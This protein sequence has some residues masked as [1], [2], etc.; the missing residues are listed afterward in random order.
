MNIRTSSMAAAVLCLATCATLA[1][2]SGEADSLLVIPPARLIV[3]ADLDS[4]AVYLDGSPV[5]FTPLTLD[6][7][8]A[9]THT[10]LV[11]S[12]SPASWFAK[13]DSLTL[14][15]VPGETRH[16]N[17]SVV[18]PLRF[19]PAAAPG[20]S[21]ILRGTT[22]HNGR[23]IALYT[24]GGIAIV[25][26]IAAA[27]FKISADDRNDAYGITGNPALL[28]ERRRLDTAAGIAFAATQIGFVVFSYLLL[29][30]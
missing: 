16:L 4:S 28:E 23:T 13:T 7:V 30:E 9:G 8:S 17:F 15:L 21:A 19:E 29:S 5:G 14:V 20:V 25:A 10:L 3:S 11:V 12:S 18:R 26:G 27:Y 6:T 24:S 2:T 22:G 1:A